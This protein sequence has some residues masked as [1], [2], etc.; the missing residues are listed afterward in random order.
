MP[1]STAAARTNAVGR[2]PILPLVPARCGSK[3]TERKPYGQLAGAA[4]FASLVMAPRAWTNAK[5][6]DVAA[7]VMTG[8]I[9]RHALGIKLRRIECGSQNGGFVEA[10]RDDVG[11]VGA[12][13]RAAASQHQRFVRSHASR[14]ALQFL[15]QGRRGHQRT[16][17]QHEAS[18]LE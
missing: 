16:G 17:G 3:I 11:A 6:K 12:D 14:I 8:D 1:T 5:L 10:R 4:K 13:D 7:A 9:Q 18:A 2:G 15:R